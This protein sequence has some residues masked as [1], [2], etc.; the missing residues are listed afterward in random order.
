[1]ED[2]I[3]VPGGKK[4]SNHQGGESRPRDKSVQTDL[5]KITLCHLCRPHGPFPQ[6]PLLKLVRE[7]WVLWLLWVFI[8]LRGLPCHCKDLCAL[9]LHSWAQT[10]TREDRRKV[11]ATLCLPRSSGGI[12]SLPALSLPTASYVLSLIQSCS[13][14]A[15]NLRW[16]CIA[17]MAEH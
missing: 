6:L 9:L 11:S 14:I 12:H 13:K 8:S 15:S 17:L 5:L 2:A 1:M 4:R 16:L 7:H 10:N 3:P